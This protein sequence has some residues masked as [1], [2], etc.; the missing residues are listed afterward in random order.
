MEI[1][2]NSYKNIKSINVD[3]NFNIELENKPAE[4]LEY[5]IRNVVSATEI[6]N[7]E[8]EA[9]EAYR[10][11]GKIEYMSLLNGLKPNYTTFS[12]FF[13]PTPLTGKNIKNS[14]DFYLCKASTGYTKITTSGT[15]YI[16]YYRVIATPNEFELYPLG[17]S[18]NV[19]GEQSYG[20]SFNI[21]FD[22]STYLDSFN[23][24][25]TELFLYAQ[26]KPKLSSPVERISYTSWDQLGNMSTIEFTPT[27]LNIGD[28]VQ[29]YVGGAY[30]PK[31]GDIIDY[32]KSDFLQTVN[33]EQTF[34]IRTQYNTGRL[35]WKYNPYTPI[36]LR[37]FANELNS[38]NTGSTSYQQTTSIPYYA[39]KI[40][41][42]N[43]YVWRDI[44]Q[45]G[46]I[47][48]ISGIGVDY[49]FVNKKRYLFSRIILDVTPDLN[50]TETRLA[51]EKIWFTKNAT[52]KRIK[53]TGDINNI[54][55]PCQ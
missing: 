19:Y 11:Y 12:D 32:S 10:I 46:Y 49:P 9:N 51:F 13:Q 23:F 14:F 29:T 5:D 20:F 55:K 45:Q 35:M 37:Y 30:Q 17:F 26:Y 21:D 48:P 33:T 1:L 53:P 6:F 40:D 41:N 54:G 42:T 44:L 43:N 22:V 52:N 8:R 28:N 50:D 31:I 16:R 27:I 39:T 2:L 15:Q 36:R 3:N 47:D 34:Y 18:N 4:I 25:A 24:P 38:V 7:A